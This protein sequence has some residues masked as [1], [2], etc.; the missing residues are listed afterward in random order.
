M[1]GLAGGLKPETGGFGVGNF[2]LQK[3]TKEVQVELNDG[4]N[5][6]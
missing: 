3:G 6:T 4:F 2:A 1:A 5:S